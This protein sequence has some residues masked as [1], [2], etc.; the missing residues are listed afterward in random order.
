MPT[1]DGV[2]LKIYTNDLVGRHIYLTGAYERSALEVL[3]NFAEPG[4]TLLDIG[5]NV[6]YIS[7]AFLNNI[8]GSKVIA[9]DPQPAVLK[10]LRQNLSQF[11][12]RFEIITAALSDHDGTE[13]FIATEGN[14]GDAYLTKDAAGS[15]PVQVMAADKALA[16][17][18]FDIVKIDVQGHEETIL[19]SCKNIIDRV[20]PRV[21]VFEESG[22]KSA[23]HGTIGSIFS[24]LSYKVF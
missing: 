4:D 10:L 13:M 18:H 24:E 21:I 2:T 6:G 12:D 5:A 22:D 23:P 17:R 16:N 19:R 8:V 15:Y 14:L 3:C 11:P 20:Q 9:I 7:T 1:T